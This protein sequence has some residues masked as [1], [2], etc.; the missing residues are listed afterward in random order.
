[1][2]KTTFSGLV[3][4]A[5]L[6]SAAQAAPA[7]ESLP[8]KFQDHAVFLK[9]SL[10]GASPVWMLLDPNTPDSSL[11]QNGSD[12][13]RAARAAARMMV[14]AGTFRQS[15]VFFDLVSTMPVTAPDGTP[16]AGRL[17]RNWIG[18]RALILVARR[19]EV[20]LAPP[21]DTGTSDPIVAASYTVPAAR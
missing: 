13:R 15:A 20:L 1:M 18:N 6:G 14:A 17:G 21:I 2:W 11:V 5:L 12:P 4:A 3:L 8:A 16:V 10:N 19:Q 7:L 9:V